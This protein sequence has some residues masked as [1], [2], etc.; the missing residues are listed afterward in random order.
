MS[1]LAAVLLLVACPADLNDCRETSAPQPMY[2]SA[3]ECRRDMTALP[4]ISLDGTQLLG[5]CVEVDQ[6]MITEDAEIVW[7]VSLE[8]ELSA[9][10]R[11]IDEPT[12]TEES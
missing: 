10:I 12:V 6:A 3:I 9:E 1:Q 8:R 7:D 2:E 5:T 11:L 4:S